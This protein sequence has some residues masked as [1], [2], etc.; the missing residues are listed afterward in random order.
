MATKL[1]GI[2][3]PGMTENE[4]IT[5]F[6]IKENPDD[7]TP[8]VVW[9]G[10]AVLSYN[11]TISGATVSGLGE[12]EN[13]TN[14]SV[15]FSA[16]SKHVFTAK[17]AT[18]TG[19]TGT[20]TESGSVTV[21]G[22]K[23]KTGLV[24]AGVAD[25]D[26]LFSVTSSNYRNVKIA[27]G[28]G[29]KSVYLSKDSNGSISLGTDLNVFD[30][31][32]YAFAVLDVGYNHNSGWTL[33]SGT[34]DTEDA[35]YRVASNNGTVD[36]DFGTI[37]ASI[38][39][40]T[41]TWTYLVTYPNTWV[42]KQETYNYGSTP[43]HTDPST[44]TS[45]KAR[46]VFNGVWSNK[47]TK[48]TSDVTITANYTT[49]CNIKITTTTRCSANIEDGWTP[50]DTTITYTADTNCAFNST[51]T[52]TTDTDTVVLGTYD[53]GKS[54]DYV[55]V[56]SLTGTNCST[57]EKTGWKAGNAKISWTAD[58]AYAFD[59][60]NTTTT[61]ITVVPGA[62]TANASY[63]KRYTLTRSVSG[64][65]EGYGTY[66]LSRTSSPYEGAGDLSFNA[67]G[68]ATIYYGDKLSCSTTATG[69]SDITW[70]AWNITSVTAPGVS[71]TGD[72]TSGNLTLTNNDNNTVELF[73]NSS[74]SAG[75]S[76][77]G[78]ANKGGTKT[79]TSLTFEKTY[80]CSARRTKSHTGYHYTYN[81]N[82]TTSGTLDGVKEDVT[83]SISFTRTTHDD[84]YEEADIYSSVVSYKTAKRST[85]TITWNHENGTK[86]A[87]EDYY[88]GE[89]P[90][91]TADTKSNTA[92]YTYTW[93]GWSPSIVTVSGNKTYTASFTSTLVDYRVKVIAAS[94]AKVSDINL[95]SS[96][97]SSHTTPL[98]LYT[99]GSTSGYNQTGF[100]Y[101]D[102]ISWTE[103]EVY[104]SSSSPETITPSLSSTYNTITVKN[105]GSIAVKLSY[106]RPSQTSA[107]TVLSNSLASNKTYTKDSL[108][109]DVSYDFKFDYTAGYTDYYNHGRIYNNSSR[110][111]SPLTLTGTVVLTMDNYTTS[112]ARTTSKSV[113]NSISTKGQLP[114]VFIA[115]ASYPSAKKYKVNIR[116]KTTGYKIT[117]SFSTGSNFFGCPD[118]L[119]IDY[120]TTTGSTNQVNRPTWFETTR[121]LYYT[122]YDADGVYKYYDGSL[123]ITKATQS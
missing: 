41:V 21:E 39:S 30:G 46:K 51:G 56:T 17:S 111:T 7:P 9:R 19:N 12:Y 113:T 70:N 32:V 54:A 87:S 1:K 77:L 75:G 71:S 93:A 121:T 69:T 80:Y 52:K 14:Y 24:Y 98:K 40:F 55:N 27:D 28:T 95:T 79:A 106:R 8:I 78:N 74:N 13:D 108:S 73:Y 31:I 34:A 18:T 112:Y 50:V 109:S 20:W 119:T 23:Y 85:Y 38:K 35:V 86:W 90:S 11:G 61:S 5:G 16:N 6:G 83:V 58:N 116:N 101:G 115:S 68:K 53:Y 63:V 66:S 45:G 96:P 29:I 102:V 36:Y 72:A 82:S 57:T 117:L 33:V 62:N 89:T 47:P 103:N 120:N 43:S 25:D 64:V 59:D 65:T 60:K 114:C 105:T 81:D 84:D 97:H 118:D 123:S 88:W 10:S 91:H 3:I 110:V 67:Q 42:G 99:S 94:G 15:S 49:E 37:D 104:S 100:Y 76:S 48:V 44:V 26:I 4:K 22:A 2:R 107:W 122:C 92:E